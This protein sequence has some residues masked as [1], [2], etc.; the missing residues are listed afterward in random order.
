MHGSS[1]TQ[2]W[3]TVTSLCQPRI[4]LDNWFQINSGLVTSMLFKF[5]VTVHAFSAAVTPYWMA[6]ASQW[7][8]TTTYQFTALCA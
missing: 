1:V 6:A 3:T 4:D 7:P 5:I 2:A 8:G